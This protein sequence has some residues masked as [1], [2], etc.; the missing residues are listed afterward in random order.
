M[1]FSE[2]CCLFV[3]EKVIFLFPVKVKV[4]QSHY[5]PGQAESFPGD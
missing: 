3:H 2:H 5:R 1:L 4:K